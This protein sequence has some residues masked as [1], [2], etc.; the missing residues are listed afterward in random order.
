MIS[1]TIKTVETPQVFGEPASL[2]DGER[3]V[4]QVKKNKYFSKFLPI[5]KTNIQIDDTDF[6][7]ASIESLGNQVRVFDHDETNNLDLISYVSCDL[8]DNNSIKKSRGL[9]Y[10]GDK[11]VLKSFPYT[12]EYNCLDVDTIKNAFETD[13]EKYSFYDAYEGALIR[14]F[15]FSSK[16]YV[17][18][19]KKFD[20]FTSKWASK[21]SFGKS[22]Q[23]ALEYLDKTNDKFLPQTDASLLERFYT[24]LDP[25]KQYMFLVMNTDDNRI[26]CNTP[27]NPTFYLVGTFVDNVLVETETES[28][29]G[30]GCV[31]RPKKHEF[32]SFDKLQQYV[33]E[34]D[35]TLLQGVVVFAPNNKQFKILN[36]MYSNLFKVRGNEPSIKYR[37]IQVRNDPEMVESLKSLYPIASESFEKYENTLK[38]IAIAIHKAYVQRYIK[39]E[40]TTVSQ[41]QFK[42]M[43]ECHFWHSMDRIK[44]KVFLDKILEI[45]N[46]QTPTNINHMI[47]QFE[48]E[49][50]KMSKAPVVEDNTQ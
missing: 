23:D 30:L 18:T 37:Y 14:V 17:S 10:N 39:K 42:V 11:L 40:F 20:A 49:R 13:F 15:N 48:Y 22:F 27:P 44:N 12:P 5:E 38:N 29:K 28:G 32:Y 50:L 19:H 25:A 41:E 7:R 21:Q 3:V 1:N 46:N 34:C 35:H 16:W 24:I 31:L 36:N 26:V 2:A 9:V 45:L 6:S 8:T 33:N 4:S 43:K 47:K